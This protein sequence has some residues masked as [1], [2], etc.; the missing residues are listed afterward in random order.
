[1]STDYV[2]KQYSLEISEH[3]CGRDVEYCII[4][5]SEDNKSAVCIQTNY[6]GDTKEDNS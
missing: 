6:V 1:M 4:Q 2:N 3:C 5:V